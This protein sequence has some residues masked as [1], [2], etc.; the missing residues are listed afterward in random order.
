M[1]NAYKLHSMSNVVANKRQRES[2]NTRADGICLS[3]LRYKD[4]LSLSPLE[5]NN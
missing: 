1:N 4:E 5:G 3:L 2:T